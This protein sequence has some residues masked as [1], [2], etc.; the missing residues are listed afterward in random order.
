MHLLIYMQ[1]VTA[2]TQSAVQ[3]ALKKG[4]NSWWHHLD[5]IWLVCIPHEQT[6]QVAFDGWHQ[7]LNTLV[8]KDNGRFLLMELREGHRINGLLPAPAWEWVRE[9]LKPPCGPRSH[10]GARGVQRQSRRRA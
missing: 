4:S 2:E 8:Q 3:E 5:N 7:W 10:R 9:H 1:G 6:C